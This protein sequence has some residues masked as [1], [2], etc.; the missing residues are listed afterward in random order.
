MIYLWHHGWGNTPVKFWAVE[1]SIFVG[2]FLSKNA[3]C[4]VEKPIL[5][6]LGE[7]LKF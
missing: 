1:K 7:R 2:E 4:G 5:G 3:K 6:N